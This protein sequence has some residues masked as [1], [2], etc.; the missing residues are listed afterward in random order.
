MATAKNCPGAAVF[1]GAQGLKIKSCPECGG[2]IEIFSRDTH[3]VCS[4]GFVAYN[5]SQSCIR[6]CAHARECVGD[7]IYEAFTLKTGGIL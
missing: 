4:C 2:E 3:A 7:E 5:D 1:K 6:W